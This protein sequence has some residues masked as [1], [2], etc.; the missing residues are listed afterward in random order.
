MPW[1]SIA[2]AIALRQL[3]SSTRIVFQYGPNVP[4]P[5]VDRTSR[6]GHLIEA[7]LLGRVEADGDV[8]VA[9]LELGDR[10]VAGEAL[11]KIFWIFG[12]PWK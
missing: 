3:T 12:A 11:M 9:R 4:T 7:A 2:Y 5:G 10:L 8:E 1:A 6:V